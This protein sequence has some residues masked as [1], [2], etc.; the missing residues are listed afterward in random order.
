[1]PGTFS[2]PARLA[3][4]CSPPTSSGSRRRPRRTK[5]APVPGGPPSLCPLID[6]RSTPRSAV[7]MGTRPAACAASTCSRI[8]RSRQASA[9]SATGCRVG[10]SW[11][12]HWRCTSA[13][14]GLVAA[15]STAGSTRPVR[16]TPTVVTVPPQARVKASAERRTAECSTPANTTWGRCPASAARR[17]APQVAAAMD[18]VAPLVKTT[19]RLRAPRSAATCARASSTATRARMPS[20]WMR[21]GSASLS[22]RPSS[23][24]SH[25]TMAARAS[26]RSGEVDAWSR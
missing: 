3:R 25:P 10:T 19:S 8:L 9:T 21:P 5:I 11:L 6:R 23:P 14:S 16:S 15:I 12:P 7:S 13:V 4:S 20:A 17:T 1:M 24:L 18:S 2:R 26:G 22:P